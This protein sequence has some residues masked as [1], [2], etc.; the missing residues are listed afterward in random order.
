MV[1]GL[2]ASP[3]ALQDP[4]HQS[5]RLVRT[6]GGELKKTGL[7]GAG[8]ERLDLQTGQSIPRGPGEREA[9]TRGSPG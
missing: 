9:A 6:R 2:P 8:D 1:A 4:L 5:P 7:D 3:V